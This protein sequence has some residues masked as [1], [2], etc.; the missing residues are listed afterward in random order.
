MHWG[1]D[2]TPPMSWAVDAPACARHTPRGGAVHAVPARGRAVRGP[3]RAWPAEALRLS[4]GVKP[5]SRPRAAV[6][7]CAAGPSGA[8]D[9]TPGPA[10]G[11]GRPGSLDGLSE[12]DL[13]TQGRAV[14]NPQTTGTALAERDTGSDLA[15]LSVSD[16]HAQHAAA[17]TGLACPPLGCPLATRSLPHLP[18]CLLSAAVPLS[19]VDGHPAAGAARH[20]VLRHSQHGLPAPTTD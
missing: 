16:N 14:V 18:T 17:H 1:V 11:Y 2:K 5:R 8:A 20:W 7:A 19:G 10:Q 13:P 4:A 3:Q 6:A 9:T 15:Y 12:D